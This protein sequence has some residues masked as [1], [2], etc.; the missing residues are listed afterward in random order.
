MG[1][2][3]IGNF[4]LC[5]IRIPLVKGEHCCNVFNFHIFVPEKAQI[6]RRQC[7][8]QAL[9]EA[10]VLTFDDANLVRFL[11]RGGPFLMPAVS[12]I[13]KVKMKE[14]QIYGSV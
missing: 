3:T 1:T 9:F 14:E 2:C 10:K 11:N 12:M 8:P 4:Q 13:K 6:K 7:C 5:S